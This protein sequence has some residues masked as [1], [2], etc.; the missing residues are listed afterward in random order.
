MGGS[1]ITKNSQDNHNTGSGNYKPPIS[2][3]QSNF[4]Q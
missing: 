2:L 3:N 1:S 4:D